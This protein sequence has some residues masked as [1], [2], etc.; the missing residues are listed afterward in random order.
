MTTDEDFRVAVTEK[1][2]SITLGAS[3]REPSVLA[4]PENPPTIIST[5]TSDNMGAYWVQQGDATARAESLALPG[6]NK[7]SPDLPGFAK[8][9]GGLPCHPMDDI[10]LEPTT[11]TMSTWR[12]NQLS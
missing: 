8:D 6:T 5:D 4:T 3:S 9:D 1:V 11:S 12:S 2:A 7:K 10:G